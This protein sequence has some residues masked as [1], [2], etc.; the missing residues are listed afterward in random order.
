MDY[1]SCFSGIGGL[2]ASHPPLVVC[3]IDQKCR[4]VLEA[5]YPAAEIHDDIRT[6]RP[7]RVEVVAGGWPCQD[8][9]IA[10]KQVGLAGDRSGLLSQLLR[11][12]KES[13]A[14]I[15][16]AENVTNLLRMSGGAEFRKA[17][18]MIHE[19]GFPYISW[20]VV[21]ARSFGLPQHRTRLLV[22]AAKTEEPTLTLFREL[23]RLSASQTDPQKK[24]LAA[25]FY[26]TA[27]IHSINYSAG[28]VPTLKVGS[29]LAIPS[30]PAVHFGDTVRLIT[31]KE[32]LKLQGF[33]DL[34][35]MLS[36]AEMY[37]AAGN[38]VARPVGEWL[39]S[40]VMQHILP[41][42]IGKPQVSDQQGLWAAREDEALYC[43][44]EGNLATT[45]SSIRGIQY[46]NDLPKAGA[47]TTN[48]VDFIDKRTKRNI[49][50]RAA[51]GLL[52]RLEKSGQACP[53]SLSRLLGSIAADGQ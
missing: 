40:G 12:A 17:L 50:S 32:A 1:V 5:R 27:G 14:R 36:S 15:L 3:E 43:V 28:Y 21:N 16:L 18:R 42:A 2:E 53:A 4:G 39:F 49:S 19:A 48:L 29:A 30:P 13:R 37:R 26:W 46:A 34:S 51:K 10:G 45:G 22:I 7:P 11:V 33:E 25:G 8:L 23:P 38:A 52:R 41:N 31:A 6:L 9:S 20:R 47:L 35:D 44:D 24:V